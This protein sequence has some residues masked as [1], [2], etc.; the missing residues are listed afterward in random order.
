MICLFNVQ[1]ILMTIEMYTKYTD[2]MVTLDIK[3][4]LSSID[5]SERPHKTSMFT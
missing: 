1:H 3:T 4:G 2:E 5:Q